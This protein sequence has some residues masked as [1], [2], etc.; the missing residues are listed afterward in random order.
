MF[1]V[2]I[3]CDLMD[4]DETGFVWTF[5]HEARDPDLIAPGAIVLA[6]DAEAPAIAEVVD[7]VD[8]RAGKV[9]HLRL[10]PGSIEDYMATRERPQQGPS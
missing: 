5:L 8:R 6:C 9:V 3:T 2:D 10:L 4:E 1:D 7:V